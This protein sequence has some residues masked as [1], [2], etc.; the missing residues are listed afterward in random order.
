MITI[1]WAWLV[2]GISIGSLISGVV[3]GF[4]ERLAKNLWNRWRSR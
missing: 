2:A 4:I 3:G 1:H